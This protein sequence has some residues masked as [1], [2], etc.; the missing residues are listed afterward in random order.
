MNA[1]TGKGS[2]WKKIIIKEKVS[3]I[4]KASDGEHRVSE[5]SSSLRALLV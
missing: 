5:V 1:R 3:P 4:L 2:S